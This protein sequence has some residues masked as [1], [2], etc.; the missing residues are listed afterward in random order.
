VLL[1]AATGCALWAAPAIGGAAAVYLFP[2]SAG[3]PVG[4]IALALLWWG[5]A[6]GTGAA[7]IVI[8]PRLGMAACATLAVGAEAL[9]M[10]F[11]WDMTGLLVPALLLVGA[12]FARRRAIAGGMGVVEQGR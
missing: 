9:L 8:A 7:L 5:G 6:L 1:V 3:S 11:G 2:H 4:W 12:G 10:G